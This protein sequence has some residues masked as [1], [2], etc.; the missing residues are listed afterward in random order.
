MPLC[1]AGGSPT[2]TRATAEISVLASPPEEAARAAEI[3]QKQQQGP[4]R[5][6]G[7]EALA[8]AAS[9][10]SSSKWQQQEQQSHILCQEGRL[11]GVCYNDGVQ[12][13]YRRLLGVLTAAAAPLSRCC[14]RWYICHHFTAAL[15]SL[16]VAAAAAFSSCIWRP[17]WERGFCCSGA[18]L[19]AAAVFT[20]GRTSCCSAGTAT[21]AAATTF[22]RSNRKSMD[23]S[24]QRKTRAR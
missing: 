10:S 24:R 22:N 15:L 23:F 14:W 9:N 1:G 16:Y 11:L 3:R 18:V 5:R 6:T 13:K 2:A 7:K 8:T 12:A 17:L 21:A 20:D 4:H 19:A